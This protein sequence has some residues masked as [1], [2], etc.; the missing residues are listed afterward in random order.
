MRRRAIDVL[1]A[2]HVGASEARVLGMLH[3]E[4]AP[5]VAAVDARPEAGDVTRGQPFTAE[6]HDRVW[7][8]MK[9]DPNQGLPPAY[10]IDVLRALPAYDSALGTLAYVVAWQ[11]AAK[12]GVVPYLLVVPEELRAQATEITEVMFLA[13]RPRAHPEANPLHGSCDFRWSFMF[14]DRPTRWYIV[15]EKSA[16]AVEEGG[17]LGPLPNIIRRETIT[18]RV[19][20]FREETDQ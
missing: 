3:G 20:H 13:P 4:P 14:S 19:A 12:D 8:E 1:T 6:A 15:G 10:P 18:P 2:R 9:E 7:R 11:H 17:A 5:N 16:I